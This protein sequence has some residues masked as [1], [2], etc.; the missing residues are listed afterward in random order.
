M[1]LYAANAKRGGQNRAEQV[2]RVYR[3]EWTGSSG[4]GGQSSPEYALVP[5]NDIMEIVDVLEELEDSTLLK[6]IAEGRKAV[7]RGAKGILFSNVL[8]Q[9]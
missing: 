8:K 5:Y 7:R 2:D 1:L 9:N 3:T 4:T 6:T